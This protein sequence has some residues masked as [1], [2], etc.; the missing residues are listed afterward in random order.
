VS[1]ELRLITAPRQ[2]YAVLAAAPAAISPLGALRRPALVALVLG[3]TIAML[4]TG[5]ATPALVAST[6]LTWSYVVVLQ[7][8]IAL[9]LV[10]PRARRTVG[11]ARAI[12]LFFAGHA[13]WS[14]FLLLAAVILPL[15]LP[16]PFTRWPGYFEA[17]AV[18]PLVLTARIVA[19]FFEQV[20]ALDRGA[21]RR[22]ALLHQAITWTVFVAINWMASA[23]LP[24][25]VQLW[26]L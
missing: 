16:P 13:P 26:T 9:A 6:T 20:L 15:P 22:A 1:P 17:T 21:A 14:I 10:A 24:R 2:T 18:V 4:S 19:A 8:A 25:L 12:D 7:L 23:F 5:R 11:V 3:V